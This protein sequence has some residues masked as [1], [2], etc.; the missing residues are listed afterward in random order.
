[1]PGLRRCEGDDLDNWLPDQFE[2]WLPQ[3]WAALTA[4]SPAQS[5]ELGTGDVRHAVPKAAATE[6]VG[7][8]EATGM[9]EES[10]E[11]GEEGAEDAAPTG[12]AKGESG[13]ADLEDLGDKLKA[14]GAAAGAVGVVARAAAEGTAERKEMVTPALRKALTKQ[15]Y[16]VIGSHSGVKPAHYLMI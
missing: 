4:V 2:A 7:G 9:P 13:L 5:T 14:A 6:S 11:E 8:E 15:G 16:R 12:T 3:L 10:D 1:M